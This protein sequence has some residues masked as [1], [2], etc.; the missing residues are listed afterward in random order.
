MVLK[1]LRFIFFYLKYLSRK[2]SIKILKTNIFGVNYGRK[3]MNETEGN[4]QLY[5]LIKSKEPFVIGKFGSTELDAVNEVI[6]N[7]LGLGKIKSKR[8]ENLVT[9]SGFFPDT[10]LDFKRFAEFNLGLYPDV[11][12]L[13][14]WNLRLED[15]VVRNYMKKTALSKL[16]FLEPYYFEKPWTL[17]LEGKKILV[18][19]PF[20]NT[21]KSQYKKR[22]F[23]FENPHILPEFQL[24]TIK[25]VQTIAGNKSEFENWF[26]AFDYMYQKALTEDF[27]LAIIGCGAYGL[28]LAIKLKQAGKQAIHLGGATQVLF[29][30]KGTRWDTHPVISKLY[31]EYWVRP[32]LEE[33][34]QGSNKVEDACYW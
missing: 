10:G 13:A 24:N 4:N 26:H 15:Y 32:S 11:D 19:H 8:I 14:I 17:A 28:P 22:Q 3:V 12:I 9:L 23:L 33:V 1:K 18:I 34:P 25:A 29:G 16:I 27:D 21:I 6:K 7:K 30:I 2:S 5:A 31:N 20:A